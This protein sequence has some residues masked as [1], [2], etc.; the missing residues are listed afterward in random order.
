MNLYY[1]VK[2]TWNQYKSEYTRRFRLHEKVDN[3]TQP[4]IEDSAFLF[5][6]IWT[7]ALALNK[8]EFRLNE[9]NLTL[10]NFTYEDQHNISE[11]IYEEVLKVKF[12]GLTVSI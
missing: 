11:I 8:T 6:A 2:Q 4:V 12:F 7:A 5:D 10:K 9:K 1:Y 3:D